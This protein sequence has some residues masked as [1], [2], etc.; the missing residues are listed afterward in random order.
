[1]AHL[2]AERSTIA[3]A[4]LLLLELLAS[5]VGAPLRTP[6]TL[7]RSLLI[8]RPVRQNSDE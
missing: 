3:V 1:V 8:A 4:L 2:A 5:F 7:I 6:R